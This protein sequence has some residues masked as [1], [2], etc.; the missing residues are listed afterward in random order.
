GDLL[1]RPDLTEAGIKIVDLMWDKMRDAGSGLIDHAWTPDSGRAGL[2]E[3]FAD[4]VQMTR[5]LLA[6]HESTGDGRYLEHA[7][8][9]AAAAD[10]AFADALNGGWMDRLYSSSAPGL[11]SWPTRSLR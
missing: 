9:L 10:K 2:A 7:A 8:A 3:F 5:A 11:L 4:Q 6:A 1:K